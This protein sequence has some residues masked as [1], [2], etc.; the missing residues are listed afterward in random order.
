[1]T[2]ADR[3]KAPERRCPSCSAVA[4]EGASFCGSCG[5]PL[6][7]QPHP[8]RLPPR[9]SNLFLD[10]G[11]L[12]AL[13]AALLVLA[14]TVAV[15]AA[16]D[17]S[18]S[19]ANERSARHHDNRDLSARLATEQRS[20]ARVQQTLATLTDENATLAARVQ[21]LSKGLASSQVGLAPLAK[22]ILRSV[23]TIETSNGLG[24]GWAAWS[25]GGYTYL[26]TAGH[27]VADDL[28]A[29]IIH[30]KVRQRATTWTGTIGATD[31]V[32]DLAVVRVS[33]Q[34]APPLWQ[35]PQLGISPLPG[36][37]LV[38]IGSPYGLEGTVTSGVVSR[39]TYDEIQTDAAANPGNSG[40]PAVDRQGDV[41]GILLAGG[42][43][44]LNF[45]VPIQR[46]CVKVRRC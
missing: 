20:L 23:F 40:G 25:A 8:Q 37:E 27:V 17:E 15:F 41:V 14:F 43:E 42:G 2:S 29:G 26:I 13:A 32:N 21:R 39:V 18:L 12:R 9:L 28:A 10:T 16:I 30:V 4:N 7:A 11:R 31:S 22:R 35:R 1:V 6:P 3:V 34:I 19:L 44:N 24:T 33:G 38:L 36:D 5:A 45:A 46:A